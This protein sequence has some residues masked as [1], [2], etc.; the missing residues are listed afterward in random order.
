MLYNEL[1]SDA[2]GP[3]LKQGGRIH[4][5]RVFKHMHLPLQRVSE[6]SSSKGPR[7]IGED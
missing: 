1:C 6:R 2:I 5:N 7:D 3:I 4:C